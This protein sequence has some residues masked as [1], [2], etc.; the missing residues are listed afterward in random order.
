MNLT[1]KTVP[2]LRFNVRRFC[3]VF[4]VMIPFSV[5]AVST[6]EKIA[7]SGVIT[8]GYRNVL[9]FSYEDAAKRPI[10]YTVDICLKVVESIKHEL[11]RDD[12]QIT[13]LPVTHASRIPALTAG[14]IDMECGL[15]TITEE[16]RIHASFSMP[17]FVEGTRILVRKSSKLASTKNLLR[18]K[19]VAPK[20]THGRQIITEIS[21]MRGLNAAIINADSYEEAFALLAAGKV[22]AF[23]ADTVILAGVRATSRAPKSYVFMPEQLSTAPI[24][25]MFRR[26]DMAFKKLVDTEVRRLI[27]SGEINTLYTHW[28][29][30]P[31]PPNQ[32]NLRLPM[33]DVFRDSLKTR[34]D[35]LSIPPKR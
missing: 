22:D 27:V 20:G 9:P 4:L 10:G 31:I 11:K 34:S 21:K 2:F 28:F 26:D 7:K 33:T 1:L 8:L 12:L 23:V 29:E 17:I 30:S 19:I 24:A 13:F 18:R 35:W 25:I 14:E 15:T 32:I 3:L 6:L 5:S 16:R